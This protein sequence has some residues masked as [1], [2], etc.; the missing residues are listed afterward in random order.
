MQ[1][2]VTNTPL[3][4]QICK[5]ESF[6]PALLSISWRMGY[7]DIFQEVPIMAQILQT[8]LVSMRMQVWSQAL[9]SGLRICVAVSCGRGQRHGL[10]PML[11]W[12]CC[13]PAD[14][15]PIWPL[16]WELPY[17]KGAAIKKSKA[18]KKKRER[19]ISML[20]LCSDYCVSNS[21][22]FIP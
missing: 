15:A 10:D 6:P 12:L 4:S 8:W 13:R 2:Y 5:M 14:T 17:A 19:H 20:T 16:A 11:L 9:L 18:K 21:H 1:Q 3:V 22:W 7:Y